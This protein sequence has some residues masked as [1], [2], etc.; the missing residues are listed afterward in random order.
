M[1]CFDR[2]EDMRR[3]SLLHEAFSVYMRSTAAATGLP[4]PSQVVSCCL[5]KEANS[6]KARTTS[7]S[8]HQ[9]QRPSSSSGPKQVPSPKEKAAK[10]ERTEDRVG[11]EN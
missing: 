2:A 6:H 11:K 3:A 1:N 5:T 8:R 7:S 4:L 10:S 9:Q